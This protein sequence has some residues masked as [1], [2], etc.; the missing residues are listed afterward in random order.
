MPT[1]SRKR[2]AQDKPSLQANTP[3]PQWWQSATGLP[4]G[5][6]QGLPPPFDAFSLVGQTFR[7]PRSPSVASDTHS[8]ASAPILGHRNRSDSPAMSLSSNTDDDGPRSAS[9]ISRRT[10]RRATRKKF[11]GVYA[12]GRGR[13]KAMIKKSNKQ[14]QL[15]VFDSETDAAT[16]V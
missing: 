14:Y 1:P 4:P 6:P 13:F 15:G 12:A 5:P 2:K 3:G 9:A 7:Q 16:S 11:R 8:A 10:V